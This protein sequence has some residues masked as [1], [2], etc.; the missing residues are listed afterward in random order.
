MDEPT[1]SLT[2][3]EVERLFGIIGVMRARGVGVIYIS[4]RLEEVLAIADRITVL[5]D[6]QVVDT[7]DAQSATIAGLVRL[8]V[9]RELA[10][11]YPKRRV[12]I[13]PVALEIRHLSNPAVGLRD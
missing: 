7:C 6:G 1:A 13:G 3:R 10:A 12:A 4:H 11:L 9:G 5:R 8:M 2:D